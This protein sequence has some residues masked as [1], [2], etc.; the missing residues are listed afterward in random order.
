MGNLVFSGMAALAGRVD[1]FPLVVLVALGTSHFTVV[2]V[3]H[4]ACHRVVVKPNVLAFPASLAVAGGAVQAE[5]GFVSIFTQVA[6]D[7]LVLR[8]HGYSHHRNSGLFVAGLALHQEMLAPEVFTTA[9]IFLN[10]LQ[11]W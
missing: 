8:L 10:V 9:Q 3:K 5:R 6:G 7:T 11:P 4:I 2:L 1:A